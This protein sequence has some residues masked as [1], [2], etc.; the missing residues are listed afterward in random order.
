MFFRIHLLLRFLPKLLI[1]NVVL[2]F[3]ADDRRIDLNRS[4]INAQLIPHLKQQLCRRAKRLL[5]PIPPNQTVHA[6]FADEIWQT[7]LILWNKLHK[8]LLQQLVNVAF[9][10]ECLTI[11]GED[12]QQPAGFG[13]A[14]PAQLLAKVLLHERDALLHRVEAFRRVAHDLWKK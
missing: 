9:G 11:L 7:D 12:P 13:A 1:T 14:K 8:L 5:E 4:N 2:I 10:V 6:L 3:L